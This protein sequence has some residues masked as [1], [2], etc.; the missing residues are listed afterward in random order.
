MAII[1]NKSQLLNKGDELTRKARFCVLDSYETALNSIKPEKLMKTKLNFQSPILRIDDLAFDL[2]NYKNIYVVGGGKASGEMALALEHILGK[3][4]KKGIVNVPRGSSPRTEIIIL[5][6]AS[7]PIPDQS[8]VEGT[9]QMLEIAG[10]ATQGDLIICLISG[11]GSSLMPMPR[12]DIALKDKQELT[13]KLLKSGANISEINTVRKHLSSFKGGFFAK[14]AYPATILNLIISDVVGDKLGDIASGPTVPDNSTFMDAQ[15]VLVKYNIWDST[16]L[17][18]QTLLKQG[19]QGKLMETPKPGQEF[20]NRVHNVILANNQSI[21]LAVKEYFEKQG[22]QTRFLTEALEGEARKVSIDLANK[23][24]LIGSLSKP[25]CLISGGET[26]VTVSGKGVG[27]RNQEL[28]IATAIQLK[29]TERFVLASLS[30]DGIDGPTDAAGAIIDSN[31]LNRAKLFG[32]KPNR[33]LN[34]NN[35]YKFFSI[36]EDLV[37]TGRTGTNVNDVVIAMLF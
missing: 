34:E 26:T 28:A 3:W 25:F 5:N 19:Q 11:G 20:F 16:P 4:I 17:S 22:T 12:E 2:R 13:Q 35:S 15:N 14:K 23:I 6:Q 27:G 30:T 7:H 24:R 31:T 29:N 21:C 18:I 9:R 33:F 10:K 37:I 8:G 32:L 1:K 36:L